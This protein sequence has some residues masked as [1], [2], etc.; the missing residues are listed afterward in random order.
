MKVVRYFFVGGVAAVVDISIFFVF[1]KLLG[2]NYLIIGACGFLIAT[3][4]NYA[5]SIRYVFESGVRFDKKY[6]VMFVYVVS[7]LGLAWHQAVLY[8]C[9]DV[10]N[11][12]LMLSKLTATGTV[13]FW[14][15]LSR[16]YW[17]FQES[18]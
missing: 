11:A 13:F 4:V 8:L 14:N 10:V 18:R 12:E 5:L 3:F 7:T 2:F 16:R 6:E 9:V 15:Y 17:I 1:A